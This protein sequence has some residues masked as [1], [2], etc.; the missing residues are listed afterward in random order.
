[1]TYA[2]SF[3]DL[4]N[5]PT[6]SVTIAV[7]LDQA[8][9]SLKE[10]RRC[11][12]WPDDLGTSAILHQ[13]LSE[14]AILLQVAEIA[15]GGCGKSRYVGKP[16]TLDERIAF[17]R[18]YACGLPPKPSLREAY[19]LTPRLQDA[20][21]FLRVGDVQS[22]IPLVQSVEMI[23]TG[24]SAPIR[25]AD[26]AQTHESVQSDIDALRRHIES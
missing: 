26:Q 5:Q 22:A 2:I 19:Y 25:S 7:L 17:L 10:A 3:A 20:E 4:V 1:M 14:V 21:D 16:A 23:V 11:K 24:R 9:R 15:H 12:Q 6:P 8:E 13:H 18:T